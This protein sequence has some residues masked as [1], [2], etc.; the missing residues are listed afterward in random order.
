MRA[1]LVLIEALPS[2][3]TGWKYVLVSA[4][5]RLCNPV[6]IHIFALLQKSFLPVMKL[7]PKVGF[8]F[9]FVAPYFL[10]CHPS[11]TSNYPKGLVALA[12]NG[13]QRKQL[14]SEASSPSLEQVY[15][16]IKGQVSREDGVPVSFN[17]PPAIFF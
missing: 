6:N 17:Q 10:F 11:D 5:P 12:S 1:Q 9:S 15:Q 7:L 2:A 16:L 4:C 13:L 3:L 14:I 8:L